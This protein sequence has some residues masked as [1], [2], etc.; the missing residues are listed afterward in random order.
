M[1]RKVVDGEMEIVIVVHVDDTLTHAKDR[2]MVER[3][4]AKLGRR[5]KLKGME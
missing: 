4:A 2:P 3:F 5:F 1:F